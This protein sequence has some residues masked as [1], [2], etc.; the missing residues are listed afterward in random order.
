LTQVY[1]GQP[2]GFAVTFTRDVWTSQN[3]LF[4]R[5]LAVSGC[6]IVAMVRQALQEEAHAEAVARRIGL[7]GQALGMSVQV[8]QPMGTHP[9]SA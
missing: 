6:G 3:G 2:P 9:R 8:M 4:P 1:P 5:E 7:A